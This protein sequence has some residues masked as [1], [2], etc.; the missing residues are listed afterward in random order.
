VSFTYV[1][2]TGSF[3]RV[4]LSLTRTLLMGTI[5]II[6]GHGWPL[7]AIHQKAARVAGTVF[8]PIG[9]VVVDAKVAVRGSSF[10]RETAT[11]GEGQYEIELPPGIYLIEVRSPGFCRARRAS[12][13]ARPQI[14]VNFDFTLLI[15]PSHSEGP[16]SY[17]PIALKSE[18]SEPTELMI[19][20]GKRTDRL[21]TI[22]FE[23][24]L[25]QITYYDSDTKITDRRQI[26]LNVT[27]TYDGWTISASRLTLNK[28]TLRLELS[29][30]VAILDGV[31]ETKVK[32]AEVD[33]ALPTPVVKVTH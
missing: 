11:N 8:D 3:T 14:K 13:R 24:A 23:G 6:V 32:S 22:E 26:Y 1:S 31:R 9:A 5:L 10:E 25:T 7:G 28:R 17:E 33:F 18:L 16:M 29:G 21:D 2:M 30:D 12:F 4:W 19:Q 15:C 20:F 27:V